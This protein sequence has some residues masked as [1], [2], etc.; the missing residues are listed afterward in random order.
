MLRLGDFHKAPQLLRIDDTGLLTNGWLQDGCAAGLSSQ[1]P[2]I[3]SSLGAFP[4][5]LHPPVCCRVMATCGYEAET[6][7]PKGGS[8]SGTHR[9]PKRTPIS[10]ATICPLDLEEHVFCSLPVFHWIKPLV[11][12]QSPLVVESP[13][14]R[15][16][17]VTLWL[18]FSLGNV[19]VCFLERP[20]S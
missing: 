18:W 1:V 4:L 7:G 14:G 8:L 12:S 16:G 3:P 2:F 19:T 20:E 11:L 17:M 6:A 5:A 13:A 9:I 15:F 10:S